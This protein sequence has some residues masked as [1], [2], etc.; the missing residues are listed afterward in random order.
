MV[1]LSYEFQKL[2]EVGGAQQVVD[3]L[4]G[5]EG[6]SGHFDEHR[7]PVRHGAVPEA[8]EFE[9]LDLHALAA[10]LGD[11]SC[12]VVN[13]VG[14]IEFLTAIVLDGADEV[15][16]IEVC[17]VTHH[18]D[19]LLRFGVD[20]CRLQDLGRDGAVGV[21]AE[22]WS[23]AG[24]TFVAHHAA[25][26]C[27]AVEFGEDIFGLPLRGHGVGLVACDAEDTAQECEHLL[28]H[29]LRGSAFIQD[30]AVFVDLLLCGDEDAADDLLISDGRDA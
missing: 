13:E 12:G 19:R 28:E 4:D 1:F 26:A 21:L 23:A 8:G 22:E 10:L 30:A 20:L 11:K 9:S 5:V 3:G 18:L 29:L 7:I 25:D 15:D 27:R 6:S 16:G 2:A 24:L 17:G 14:E